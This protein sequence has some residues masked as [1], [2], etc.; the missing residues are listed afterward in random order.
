MNAISLE[1][2]AKVKGRFFLI[3]IPAGPST[4]LLAS[5]AEMVEIDQDGP[6]AAFLA[7]SVR[8]SLKHR[9]QCIYE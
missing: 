6:V 5:V 1:S 3:V 2:A 4:T 8:S 9:S 7:I